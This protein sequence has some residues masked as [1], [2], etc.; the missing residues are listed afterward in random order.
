MQDKAVGFIGAG[1]IG[2]PMM[3][4]L[5]KAGYSV[6]VFDKFRTAAESVME[7]GAIWAETPARAAEGAK[8]VITCLARP[9]HVMECMLG[10]D[11]AV[12]GMD[13]GATWV[14]TSTTDYHS[15]M[16]IADAARQRGVFS[17]EA[18]VSNLSHM[19]VDF[20]N[21]SAY[22][23]GDRLGYDA[24]KG[25]LDVMTKV[26]F[27][28]GAFGTAQTVKLLTN[29]LFYGSVTICGDCLAMSQNAGIP[30]HWMWRHM[31]TTSAHSVPA[32]QFIPMLLDGS[33]DTSC[34]LEIGVKDMN[35]TVLIADEHGVALPLG[36]LV[37][38]RYDLA[39][40][41]YDQRQNHMKAIKLTEDANDMKIRIPGFV[42]PSKYGRDANY[43]MGP[44]METDLYG[45]LT[46]RLPDYCAAPDFTP[47]AAQ[48]DLIETLINFMT[49]TNYI[50]TCEAFDLGR[51]AGLDQALI[52]EMIIWSVGTNWVVENFS[53]YKPDGST[54]S[55]MAAA[56]Q[57]LHLPYTDSIIAQLAQH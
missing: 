8:V 45:R 3:M 51:A 38:A 28:T 37:C 22:C 17:I 40:A 31:M 2:R 42:A 32:A 36:R 35:L 21:S 57:V 54:L 43:L 15:T 20:G 14:N 26:S 41:V 23:A 4:A 29:H 52:E 44:E 34:S 27:F 24:A 30:T 6:R 49:Y 11:G 13:A 56:K 19:G 10:D 48:H 50:L 55:A 25:I 16:K 47:N 53:Q 33:Y 5:L 1:R 39:G 46:P 7:A 9:E 12:S 18:P